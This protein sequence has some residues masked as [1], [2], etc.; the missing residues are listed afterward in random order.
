MV[1]ES[2]TTETI[3]DSVGT[4]ITVAIIVA[5]VAVLVRRWRRATPA[6]RRVLAPVYIAGGAA[7]VFLLLGN[8]LSQ[9]STAASDAIGSVFLLLFAAVPF[10]FLLGILRSRLARGSVGGLVVSIGQGMPLRD[11]IADA[12]GD[13]TLELAYW[14]EEGQRFVDRDGRGF[15]LPEP[16]SGRVASI[17]ERDGRRVGALVH[18]ESLSDE[19]E[20][21]ESVSAAVALALDNERLETELR[22]QYDFLT[23]IVDTA[24]SLLVSIDVEGVIRNLNPA[25]V[26]ASG[27][28]DEEQVSGR[29]FWDV[30]I[31]AA[32]REAMI[33]RFRAAAPEFAP[34]EY[35][36]DFTNARGE[37][38]VIAWRSAPV[39][40]ETGKVVRIV[41]GGLDITLRK[42]QEEELRASRVRIVAA[43]DDER[44]R[45]ERNLHD[46]AQQRLV[47]LSLALRLV[48]AKLA[49]DP[50]GAGELLAGASDELAQALEELRELARGIHPAVL[51]DRGLNAALEGLAAR[52]PLPVELRTLDERLPESIEAAA[53]Y[54]VAEAIT[55]VVKHA[56]ASSVDVRVAAD[57][58]TVVIEVA[59]DGVG[60]ADPT[61]GSGLRGL[62]DRLAALD[63]QAQS[64]EPA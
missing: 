62:A 24:P 10:A 12:L 3:V 25:T 21:I 51:T 23:T 61:G 11:G 5:V 46:G 39:L 36:N 45:L 22:A 54:V 17:V 15:E 26:A 30:F 14:L 13:P 40:D 34:A 47:A 19:P 57:N 59:D 32:E 28:D 64:R 2:P 63:G 6:L 58:G 16:G 8:V 49:S 42:Q 60:A 44:R 56:E 33:G 52:T 50:E 18:D 55:N 27:Y 38:R 43:G 29:Y 9:V 48:Q 37:H 20:L 1:V 4:A 31:D 53:Y 41:A 7:L 35:E